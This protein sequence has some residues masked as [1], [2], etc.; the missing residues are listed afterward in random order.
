MSQASDILW[1]RSAR[2]RGLDEDR[3]VIQTQHGRGQRRSLLRFQNPTVRPSKP[4][5]LTASEKDSSFIC[6]AC[7]LSLGPVNANIVPQTFR[8]VSADCDNVLVS[9][10]RN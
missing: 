5:C 3:Q 2:G 7:V 8:L 9:S 10:P 6:Q 4:A 1:S